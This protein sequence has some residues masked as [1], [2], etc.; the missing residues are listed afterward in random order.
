MW[1]EIGTYRVAARGELQYDAS[2]LYDLDSL[3][4][5]IVNCG[6]PTSQT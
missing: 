5:M 4:L 2:G 6:G 1:R 3:G